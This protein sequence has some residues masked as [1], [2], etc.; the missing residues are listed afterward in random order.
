NVFFND[1]KDILSS[2]G[3]S[4]QEFH[5]IP[6]A[7]VERP[8]NKGTAKSYGGT[9]RLDAKFGLSKLDL[10]SYLA[11]TFIDGEIDGGHIPFSA[12]NTIKG[13]VDFSLNRLSLSP[14]FIYRSESYHRSLRDEND[15]IVTNDPFT[16][17][18]LN[19]RYLISN[20]DI[21]KSAVYIKIINL[22]NS[23]Y[24]NLPIGG[25]ECFP[26]A[27]QDPIRVNF[28]LSFKFL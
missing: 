3:F 1:V 2:A 8:V 28:G 24:Y 9:V 19:V 22:L 20:S 18:N 15:N 17:V 12:K 16:L 21:L 7:Y 27:P 6:V 5:G 10:N 13:G 4:G 14:R 26:N 25:R 11:Y 23:K